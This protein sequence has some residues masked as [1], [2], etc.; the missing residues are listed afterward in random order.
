MPLSFTRG[1][2]NK[3]FD[4]SQRAKCMTDI[5]KHPSSSQGDGDEGGQSFE[6]ALSTN[7][8]LSRCQKGS[9]CVQVGEQRL[10]RDELSWEGGA[11][12]EQQDTAKGDPRPRVTQRKALGFWSPVALNSCASL[13]G[14][15]HKVTSSL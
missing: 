10:G 3:V 14:N 13:M 12:I 2:S 9:V 4:V 1:E 5:K 15:D 11:E 8:I 7:Q 6:A